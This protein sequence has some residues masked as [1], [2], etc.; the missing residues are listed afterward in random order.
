MKLITVFAFAALILTSSCVA[1]MPTTDDREWVSGVAHDSKVLASD[2]GLVSNAAKAA[3]LESTKKY[4]DLTAED[5]G[6]ALENSQRY[7]VSSELQS[8]KGYFELALSSIQ[9]GSEKLSRGCALEDVNLI[10][11]GTKLIV[12]GNEYLTL[13]TR[14]L[15]VKFG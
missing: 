3:D 14:E 6:I 1:F 10:T 5:A 4:C 7:S 15:D 12:K 2:M 8:T 11:E 9:A 13:A